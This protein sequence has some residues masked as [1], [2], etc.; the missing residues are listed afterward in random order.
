MNRKLFGSLL[1]VTAAAVAPLSVQ[2]A[3]EVKVNFASPEKFIDIGMGSVDR[4]RVL[5]SLGD[6]LKSLGAQG[7]PDAQTLELEITNID[8]AGE[9]RFT[10]KGDLRV[11][12]GRADW[13]RIELRYTL[14]AGETVLKSGEAKLSDVAYT[15]GRSTPDLKTE[16]GYEKRMLRTWFTETFGKP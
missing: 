2:A 1:I 12:R 4:E 15:S 13:P 11:M 8:L 16:F 7:L 9:V 5:R 10:P 6:F 3:G 14:R